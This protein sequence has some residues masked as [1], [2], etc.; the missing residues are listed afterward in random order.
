MTN[1][2]L[3]AKT[4]ELITIP[5]TADNPAALR[6]AVEV[7]ADMVKA[8]K[9]VTI[10]WFEQNGKPSF[11]AYRGQVRPSTFDIILNA[12]L[13]V[14]PGSPE[15]FEPHIKDGRLYGR[16]ALDMK[17]TAVVL[18]NVFCE[19]V[20]KVPYG[21]GLQIVSDEEI[22]GYDGVRL[23]ISQGV[24]S[25][26]VIIGEYANESNVIYNAARG[27]CWAEI[28]FKGKSAHG[29]H[30]WHGSNAV[31]KA[32]NFAAAVLDHY[33]TPD[34]ES[35]TTT[36]SIANLYTPNQTYNKVPDAAVLKID[37][38]FTPEDPVFESKESIQAFIASID[39]EAELVNVATFE[40]AVQVEELN[41]YVQ[42]LSAA[43]RDVTHT[44]P[45]YDARPGGS[46][47]RH[48]ALV[49]NDLVE[50][51]LYGQHSHG[52][53]EYVELHSF[54]EYR[55]IL[56]QFLQKPLLTEKVSPTLATKEPLRLK[57]LRQLVAMPTVSGDLAAN[58]K[59][60]GFIERFL[61]DRGM[62]VAHCT[63]EGVSSLL[64]TTVPNSTSPAV[65]LTAHTDVVPATPEQFDLR[66]TDGR[67]YGRGTI[68]MKFAIANYLCLVDT[69]KDT[70]SQYDFGILITSDEE[71]GG[72]HGTN[73]FVNEKG[74]RPKVAIV[75][76]G[77]ENWQ[78]ET[79]AKGV[80]WLKVEATGKASHASRP[81]EGSNAISTLLGALHDI[82]QLAPATPT[83]DD[84]SISIGTIEGG[85]AG[86]QIPASA[87]ALLD[88]RYGS[89]DDF[90]RLP[91]QIQDIC[92]KHGVTSTVLVNDP[93]CVNDIHDPFI[94]AFH[95]L[96]TDVTGRVPQTCRSYGTT[97]GRYFSALGIPSVVVTP[98]GAGRH[99][100]EEW[101]SAEGFEQFGTILEAYV[102]R[103]S[104]LSQTHPPES[105]TV[106]SHSK[107]TSRTNKQKT[108]VWYAMYG[109]GL[110]KENFLCYL[111]GGRPE[112]AN[113]SYP[114]C[115]DT[116]PPLADVFMPLPY[117]LYFAGESPI[118]GGGY[119]S[120]HPTPD[121]RA[122]TISRAYLITLEQFEEIA[123]QHSS[124][125]TALPLPLAQ[126]VEQ[127]HA[128]IGDGSGDYDELVY[129]GEKDG[130][131]IYTLT[132]TTPRLPYVPPSPVYARLVCKGLSEDKDITT[133]KAINYV[134]AKPGIAGHYQK[135][136]LTALFKE[137]TSTTLLS[138]SA[139]KEPPTDK[140][141]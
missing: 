87:S 96:I 27:L 126:A 119:V 130:Y 98:E 28:A 89:M 91:S 40:P 39:P 62:H 24:R 10:E 14:V 76:D 139:S 3:I 29:G 7:I 120:I 25:K 30:L 65:L 115:A 128:T 75:P 125:A 114:G 50:F 18:A 140:L 138:T 35:W 82:Q 101:L 5:S 55:D 79:F 4:K 95:S 71:T 86:N 46:D 102:R 2:Q 99:T 81:W 129:C 112:D 22:G 141:T 21:L 121:Q 123:A 61:T 106:T 12:H 69:L 26:F 51:G 33:P 116:T 110:S 1:D 20:N 19:M 59:A 97:D 56:R 137:I 88:I 11:L 83:R 13:D 103:M 108:Y 78:I 32:G 80:Q 70:L 64:A 6:Q 49:K 113:I 37:F 77:G 17:G 57:L 92:Q 134:L 36:A 93:P 44:E 42:G 107:H 23:H 131:P 90:D 72:R 84:T 73:L 63:K 136:D 16:G 38:R 74:L 67:L 117:M 109:S 133:Q 118:W 43:M 85:T 60:L 124:R 58:N 135:E 68:D 100:N 52:D 15:L 111:Q 41:P 132:A 31:V 94:A 54:A 127:G 66:L 122:R 9:G 53:G 8:V 104:L 48:Y 105:V 45:R 47:G 34:K